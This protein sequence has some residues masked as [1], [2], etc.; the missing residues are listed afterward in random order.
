VPGT[1]LTVAL[2]GGAGAVIGSGLGQ[3]IQ[4]LRDRWAVKVQDRHRAEDARRDAERE[5]REI[6]R[7]DYRDVLGFIARVRPSVSR[8]KLYTISAKKYR[9]TSHEDIFEF[10]RNEANSIARDLISTFRTEWPQE[11]AKLT[12]SGSDEAE[13]MAKNVDHLL[14]D[15]MVGT[16]DEYDSIAHGTET[17]KLT[18]AAESA[19]ALETRLEELRALLRDEQTPT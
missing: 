4:W 6:R 9:E 13:A 15:V 18:R 10:I 1:T 19:A 12:S 2:A 16:D 11:E 5:K 3:G 17:D 14:L 7:A 8:L